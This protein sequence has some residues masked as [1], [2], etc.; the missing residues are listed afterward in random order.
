M[1]ARIIFNPAAGN[2]KAVKILESV[3]PY[4]R[5]QDIEIVTTK[6]PGHATELAREVANE[7]D[8]TVI[9]LGG[10]GTHHEVIN[11]LMPMGKTIFGVIPA[12]TGNDFVRVL[13]Y[14]ASLEQ[15]VHTA[16]Y[17]PNRWFDL[18]AIDDQYFL[19]VAGAG[20]DAE[21]AGWANKHKKQGNGTWVFIRGILYNALGY[22]PQPM[23]V[24]IDG[25][26]TTQ[27]TFMIAMGNTQYIA[28]GMNICPQAD[29]HDG[30][31][32]IMWVEGIKPWQILPLLTRVFRGTH[33]KRSVVKTFPARELTVEGPSGLWVHADG[34]LIGHLP[35][36]V[37]TIPKAI[38]V[39][40][41]I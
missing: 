15:M 32:E 2:G 29:P 41:G 28:G 33:V 25:H 6:G 12:G 4:L 23:T 3:K 1:A 13:H 17:G 30:Q 34:E 26:S 16:L 7:E 39:H 38:R 9:S 27:N 35:V 37:K 10:D 40:M 24:T 20:F 5:D 22:R 11:G 18:G 14:P 31:F 19:T 8:L 21:V 36:H